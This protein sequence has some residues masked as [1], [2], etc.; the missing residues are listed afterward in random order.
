[1]STVLSY[2]A[3]TARVMLL[4]L[5][6]WLLLRTFWLT[7]RGRPSHWKKELLL[8]LFAL[9]LVGLAVQT[10]SS[11]VIVRPDGLPLS[12]HLRDRWQRRLAVNLT[13]L[14]TIRAIWQRGSLEQK[15]VNLAGNV[16]FFAPLGLLPPLLWR[17]PRHWWMALGL[18]AGVSALIECLQFFIGRSVDVDDLLLNALGGLTG[19]LL[20]RLLYILRPR[21]SGNSCPRS[22]SAPSR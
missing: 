19:Y 16:L 2:L 12:D 11:P 14:A 10:L 15:L 6:P 17:R 4:A 22:D 20:F 13:P 5:P 3:Q 18:S 8:A 9:Y 1:M 7:R 21:Q